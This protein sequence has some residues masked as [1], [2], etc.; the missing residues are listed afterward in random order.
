MESIHNIMNLL[1]WWRIA[2]FIFSY[3][4]SSSRC[5]GGGGESGRNSSSNSNSSSSS[6]SNS[7]CK[8]TNSG[9][10]MMTVMMM[11]MVMKMITMMNTNRTTQESQFISYKRSDFFFCYKSFL[12]NTLQ[13]K[14]K[15]SMVWSHNPEQ[16]A[17]TRPALHGT[18]V[19]R[20]WTLLKAASTSMLNNTPV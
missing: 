7:N 5:G 9:I 18:V 2:L 14:H 1:H 8:G 17:N 16:H 11:M 6:C 13:W 10:M 20:K 12:S 4:N 19:I 3:R 15:R